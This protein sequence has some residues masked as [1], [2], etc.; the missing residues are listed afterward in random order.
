[1]PRAA[2]HATRRQAAVIGLLQ[3]AD[4]RP[5]ASRGSYFGELIAGPSQGVSEEM[6]L[7]R[8][9]SAL[10]KAAQDG[11]SAGLVAAACAIFRWLGV[12]VL[13][14][15]VLAALFWAM[16]M[17]FFRQVS[18]DS[19]IEEQSRV[20]IHWLIGWLPG[21]ARSAF[22]AFTAG[23]CCKKFCGI[24]SKG[25]IGSLLVGSGRD[26]GH[27]NDAGWL[28]IVG[29]HPDERPQSTWAQTC[30]ARQLNQNQ[31]FA[32]AVSKFFLWHWT[33]PLAYLWLLGS[34]RCSVATLGPD[35]QYLASIVAAREVLYMLS[36]IFAVVK[37]PV[38]LLLDLKTVWAE[39]ETR[40]QRFSRISIYT[41]TPHNFVALCC[42]NHSRNWGRVFVYLAAVQML[43]DLSSCYALAHLMATQIQAD[44]NGTAVGT[45]TAVSTDMEDLRPLEIGYCMTAFAFLLFIGPL[46]VA[47]NGEA[48]MSKQR[49]WVTR[50]LRGVAAVLLLAGWLGVIVLLVWLLGGGNPF[51]SGVPPFSDEIPCNFHG[52][53][54]SAGLCHCELGYGPEDQRSGTSLCVMDGQQCTD[55]QIMLANSSVECAHTCCNSRG[56]C[57]SHSGTCTDCIGE[58]TGTRCEITPCQAHSCGHGTCT[59]TYDSMHRCTCHSGWVGAACDHATGCDGD[60]CGS[61]KQEHGGCTAHGGL[62]TC[63]CDFG[64]QGDLCNEPTGCLSSPCENGGKCIAT[65]AEYSC[66]CVAGWAGMT[67]AIL[68]DCAGDPCGD[69]GVKCV[70]DGSGH[71]CE[72]KPGWGDADC[73]RPTGCDEGP[74]G[75]HGNCAPNGGNHT[76]TCDSGFSGDVCDHSTGCDGISPCMNGGSCVADGGQHS[77]NCTSG[78]RGDTCEQATGCDGSP[79]ANGGACT[80]D[81]GSYTC[82]CVND[83][84][85]TTCTQAQPAGSLK[86]RSTYYCDTAYCNKRCGKGKCCNG[87]YTCDPNFKGKRCGGSCPI[88]PRNPPGPPPPP[89]LQDLLP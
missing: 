13:S 65:G 88:C 9:T 59:I 49:H 41:L 20:A 83:W 39:A 76:C 81:G 61:H 28:A 11:G 46:S 48:A 23:V 62:F 30:D 51:C 63:G 74:C 15:P 42:S 70:P 4:S 34:F 77:C 47:T 87:R 14:L 38:F 64:W 35:Q 26:D 73:L 1:M 25:L 54:F 12:S 69:N 8:L 45:G 18:C 79:C 52:Q 16:F 82:A 19:Y 32:I 43:A 2:A 33:Q 57:E 75:E 5:F 58:Y 36:T 22:I 67:C 40:L 17:L 7:L 29:G 68:T 85:G 6:D 71:T 53:C 3:G 37:C 80:P 56:R 89:H 55:S 50:L 72:C 84:L 66:E 78:W 60:P 21:V 24:E 10:E 27:A 31:S 44:V 86:C